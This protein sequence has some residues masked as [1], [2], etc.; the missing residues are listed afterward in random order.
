MLSYENNKNRFRFILFAFVF[1]CKK[2]DSA[3]KT[4]DNPSNG[5]DIV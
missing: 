1:S 3:A 4:V 5:N 2:D